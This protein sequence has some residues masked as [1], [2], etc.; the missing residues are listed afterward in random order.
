[1]SGL[2][3]LLV[4]LSWLPSTYGLPEESDFPQ[5]SFKLFNRFI[6]AN[7]GRDISLAS[8]LVIL[9]S[10]IENTDLL[11]LHARQ[12]LSIYPGEYRSEANGWI[13]G[14]VR[15]LKEELV[16]EFDSL[17]TLSETE[18]SSSEDQDLITVA[19]KL[20]KLAQILKLYPIT[21]NGQFEGKLKPISLN[22]IQPVHVITPQAVVCETVTCEPRS[23]RQNT[24][25]RDIPKVVLIKGTAIYEKVHVLT[26]KCPQCETMYSADHERFKESETKTSRLYLNSA[27]YIKVGQELWVDRIFSNAVLSGMYSFHASAAAYAEFWNNSF[28]LFHT[29]NT[30]K[31]SRRQ[32]WATFVQESTRTIAAISNV[33]LTLQDGL[34]LDEVT[35]EAFTELGDNG[36][37]RAAEGH[38]CSECTHIYKETADI[39]TADD[40][41]AL[42]GND[43]N[44]AVPSLVGE[45]AELAERDAIRARLNAQRAAANARNI[46]DNAMDIDNSPVKMIVLDGI[47]MGPT[48]CAFEE[49]L[50]PL[51]NARGGVFCAGHEKKYKNKCRIRD[52][53]HERV[54]NTQACLLHQGQWHKYKSQHSR[55]TLSG[56]KRMLQRPGE[57]MDW[58]SGP[59]IHV[60]PHDEEAVVLERKNYFSPNC[61]YCVETLCAPCGVVIAWTKFPKA[62]SP[63]NILKFL[64][65]V[66]PSEISRPDYICIDK[67]CLV[68]RTSITNESWESWKNTSRFIVDSYH[69]INH[70]TTDYLCRKWCNPAPLNGSAPNLVIVEKDKHGRSYYKRAFNT[71]VS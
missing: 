46:D 20:D 11:S 36:L 12:K 25:P 50:L 47:V 13:K 59:R 24:K 15:A 57:K 53:L 63:T 48:Y 3:W 9:F 22:S 71:Q 8:V 69:Y 17:F 28:W 44:R 33:N 49:C 41:A 43:E 66:Y 58:Q 10:M 7:F 38:A 42:V 37:I 40:P 19:N 45:H 23:L 1:M 64:A 5:L 14:L 52:C 56:V 16:E 65:S 26:G 54:T 34:G 6:K 60:Q 27:K 70:R 31:L 68:L 62:E 2:I 35:K 18:N 51:A 61:F 4:A 55:Q 30:R 29:G 32:I 21:K 39:I 67:A